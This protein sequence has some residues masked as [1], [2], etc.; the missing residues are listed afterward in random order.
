MPIKTTAQRNTLATAYGNAATEARLYSTVP[1]TAAGTAI[2][3]AA[4]AITWSA[5]TNG[6]ITAEV[7][8]NVPAGATVAGAGVHSA[9]GTYLDGG[10]VPSQPFASDG[11][12]TLTLT[13]TQ[14]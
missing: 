9:T 1:D 4:A 6:V 2:V 11:T 14:S 12:Y 10:A 13:Y 5:P 3:G 7:T 8:F